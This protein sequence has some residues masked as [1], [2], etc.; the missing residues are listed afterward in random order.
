MLRLRELRIESEKTQEQM[1]QIL[2]VSRQVYANHENEVNE[3]S[4]S[5]LSKMADFFQCSIDYLLGRSDDLG[6]ISIKS[7]K[8][9]PTMTAEEQHL[10]ETFRAL[11]TKNKLHVSTYADIRLEEQEENPTSDFARPRQRRF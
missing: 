10:L 11:N 5:M 2:G 6:V 1:A 9:P 4:L 3:P 7:E 8:S